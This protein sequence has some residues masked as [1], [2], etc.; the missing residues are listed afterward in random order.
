MAPLDKICPACGVLGQLDLSVV[1]QARPLGDWS[2]A[3]AQMKTSASEV[4]QLSCGACEME[5][6]GRFEQGYAVFTPPPGLVVNG[7]YGDA[8]E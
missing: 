2:L 3:G 6:V 1:L 7:G 4:P 5:I 8:D